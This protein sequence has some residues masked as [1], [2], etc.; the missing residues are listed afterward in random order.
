[1][2]EQFSSTVQ[3]QNF[4][5]FVLLN[6]KND[7]CSL[8]NCLATS[9]CGKY[10]LIL[11]AVLISSVRKLELRKAYGKDKTILASYLSTLGQTNCRSCLLELTDDQNGQLTSLGRLDAKVASMCVLSLETSDAIGWGF[12]WRSLS[13]LSVF[14]SDCK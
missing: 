6:A 1:M 11:G 5:L 3:F 14:F 4:C 8:N 9:T 10:L 7:G 2:T 12:E 13:S